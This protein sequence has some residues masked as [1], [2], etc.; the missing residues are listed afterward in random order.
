MNACK[1][2]H[3]PLPLCGLFDHALAASTRS[4][5]DRATTHV[6]LNHSLRT[7]CNH[8]LYYHTVHLIS[9]HTTVQASF[10]TATN[11]TRMHAFTHTRVST[12]AVP[13]NHARAHNSHSAAPMPIGCRTHFTTVRCARYPLHV[14]APTF[15][16][17]SHKTHG[18]TPHSRVLRTSHAQIAKLRH[19]Y[20]QFALTFL[21]AT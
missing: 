2:S 5:S 12:H 4:Y 16:G 19:F 15:T 14:D 17:V 1:R 3:H 18:A 13:Q 9:Q 20:A 7:K 10:R 6:E 11:R 21:S 8:R